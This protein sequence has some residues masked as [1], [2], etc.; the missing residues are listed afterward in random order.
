MKQKLYT[1]LVI[2]FALLSLANSF[3]VQAQTVT[4]LKS[5]TNLPRNEAEPVYFTAYDCDGSVIW[6][7]WLQQPIGTGNASQDT[8][9]YQGSN[10]YYVKCGGGPMQVFYIDKSISTRSTR[11]VISA[12][13]STINAGQSVTLSAP[14]CGGVVTWMS[15]N[16][17]LSNASS[18]NASPTTNTTYTALCTESGRAVSLPS[19]QT[20]TIQVNNQSLPTPVI[21]TTDLTGV[22]QVGTPTK[23]GSFNCFYTVNWLKNGNYIGTG[24]SIEVTAA[25]NDSYTATCSN[26]SVVSSPSNVLTTPAPVVPP[27][28]INNTL[29]NRQVCRNSTTTFQIDA[30]GATSFQWQFNEQ[31]ISGAYSS[32]YTTSSITEGQVG[33][34]RVI[35]SNS[36]GSVVSNAAQV[37]LFEPISIAMSST[38]TTCF[39]GTNGTATAVASN[40]VAPYTYSWS[41]SAGGSTI[42]NLVAGSYTVTVTGANGCTNTNSVSVSQPELPIAITFNASSVTCFG[43]SNGTATATA[44]RGTAPYTFSWSNGA[45]GA[46]VA[47]PSGNFTVTARDANGCEASNTVFIAQ[48]SQLIASVTNRPVLCHGGNDGSASVSVSGGTTPYYYAWSNGFTGINPSGLTAGSYFVLITDAN[49][50]SVGTITTVTQPERLVYSFTKD[51]VKCFG[52]NDGKIEVFPFGGTSPYQLTTNGLL[53]PTSSRT[54][55]E[56]TY[57]INVRDANNC[58]STANIVQIGQPSSPVTARLLSSKSPRGFGLTDGSITVEI[59]GGTGPFS[60]FSTNWTWSGGSNQNEVKTETGGTLRTTLEKAGGGNYSLRVTDSQFGAAITQDG[61]TTTLNYFLE[62]PEKITAITQVDKGVSCFGKFDGQLSAVVKGGVIFDATNPYKY[63]WFKRESGSLV[64]LNELANKLINVDAGR[65]VLRVTDKNDIMADFEVELKVTPS[66]TTTVV[67]QAYP[68]CETSADGLI[69]IKTVGGVN[70][71]VVDWGQGISGSRITNLKAG[72]YFGVVRDKEGCTGEIAVALTP[73]ENVQVRVLKKTESI[74]NGGCE[75]A[76]DLQV[77]GNVSSFSVEW[78]QKLSNNSINVLSNLIGND[79]KNLCSGEYFATVTT[80]LGCKTSTGS[81]VLANPPI[82]TIQVSDD[83]Q[84]CADANV[85]L[86]AA[87]LAPAKSYLWKLPSGLTTTQPKLSITQNGNYTL[88]AIDANGCKASDTFTVQVVNSSKGLLFSVASSGKVGELLYAVNLTPISQ[89]ISWRVTG[90]AKVVQQDNG[91][92]VFNPTGVGIIQIEQISTA[93]GC[94]SNIKRSVNITDGTTL[95]TEKIISSNDTEITNSLPI[96]STNIIAENSV[97]VYPNPAAGSFFIKTDNLSIKNPIIR[98]FE[99]V[100]NTLVYV[101]ELTEIDSRG[102]PIRL[103]AYSLKEGSYYVV[104]EMGKQRV[105]KILYI[106]ESGGKI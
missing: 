83:L 66:L 87:I 49:N 76:I 104:I 27:P 77:Q 67:A 16:F 81:I 82:K 42:S 91:L 5:T 13:A 4:I 28:T 103:D 36:S 38:P 65:Y 58:L 48:P 99:S 25:A 60:S 51:D 40:G 12:S 63:Q 37:S 20:V 68:T 17:V 84:V 72:N 18:Y 1:R 23:I 64:G 21:N 10:T 78:T 14:N 100:M 31:N 106:K 75:G 11:P 90:P 29:T 94:T 71:L 69:E 7:N 35:V 85:E 55:K 95:T 96:I 93:G 22:I 56:G 24:T 34:Y 44:T 74:C 46:N 70:P 43:G 52:G 86:D 45:S 54:F 26:G 39:A 47:L 32:T 80:A 41:N 6:Y 33:N 73:R 105:V 101:E 53:L 3:S 98:I 79:A 88:E 57:Q 9:G 15:G 8:P 59:K 30:T 2:L 102:V 92:L 62:Q 61:C 50:C 97:I 19:E 89:P